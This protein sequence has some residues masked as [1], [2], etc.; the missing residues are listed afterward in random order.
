M[1]TALVKKQDILPFIYF[2]DVLA[3][4]VSICDKKQCK[5]RVCVENC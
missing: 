5:E 4:N 1:A 2:V 3:A